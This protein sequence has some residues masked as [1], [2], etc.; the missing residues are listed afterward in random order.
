MKFKSG[1]YRFLYYKSCNQAWWK[2]GK[3]NRGCRPAIIWRNGNKEWWLRGEILK[4]QKAS[5]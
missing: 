5:G 4:A 3:L 2:D 1:G